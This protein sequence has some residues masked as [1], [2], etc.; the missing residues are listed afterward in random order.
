MTNLSCINMIN[1][2]NNNNNDNNNNFEQNKR[3]TARKRLET[4]S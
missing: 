2:N 3:A 4:K 1:N